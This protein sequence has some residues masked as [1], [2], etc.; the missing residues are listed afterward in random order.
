[1]GFWGLA[2]WS[3]SSVLIL[4]LGFLIYETGTKKSMLQ[5]H[6]RITER[7]LPNVPTLACSSGSFPFC[8]QENVPLASGGQ[9]SEAE[10]LL[11]QHTGRSSLLS[12]F[13]F[14]L[15]L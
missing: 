3:Q 14:W 8:C 9:G 6:W 5:C 13:P 10:I 4:S 1:M 7:R 15:R 12:D 2:V 11:F